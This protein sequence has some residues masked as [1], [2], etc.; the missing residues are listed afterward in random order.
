MTTIDRQRARHDTRPW[1]RLFPLDRTGRPH[2]RRT[3]CQSTVATDARVPLLLETIRVT[4]NG[5]RSL[6]PQSSN[7]SVLGCH[8][9]HSPVLSTLSIRVPRNRR[10]TRRASLCAC[11]STILSSPMQAKRPGEASSSAPRCLRWRRSSP[12]ITTMA[13]RCRSRLERWDGQIKQYTATSKG[14]AHYTFIRRKPDV[15]EQ[16]KGQVTEACL[17]SLLNQVI[18]DSTFYLTSNQ[19][20]RA[21]RFAPSRSESAA[22]PPCICLSLPTDRRLLSSVAHA[23]RSSPSEVW[24]SP[25][26]QWYHAP[27]THEERLHKWILMRSDRWSPKIRKAF[28]AVRAREQTHP[29]RQQSRRSGRAPDGRHTAGSDPRCF[30]PG[31]RARLSLFGTEGRSEAHLASRHRRCTLRSIE[32]RGRLVP[33]IQAL[34]R[35]WD[36]ESDRDGARSAP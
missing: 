33:E 15:I 16:L 29:A 11:R 31:P 5:S 3:A 34:L 13:P 14:S 20:P 35:H 21:T 9:S 22:H 25:S 19:Q 32:R 2:R 7:G 24:L 6:R 27:Y 8:R 30:A 23:K 10:R 18:R 4:H 12:S 28:S 36:N 1:H 17:T 26:L